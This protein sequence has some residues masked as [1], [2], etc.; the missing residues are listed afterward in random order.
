MF[1]FFSFLVVNTN[2]VDCLERFFSEMT[3]YVWS[4]TLNPTHSLRFAYI[5]ICALSDQ[6]TSLERLRLECMD[7]R[8]QVEE[9]TNTHGRSTDDV[10]GTPSDVGSACEDE[11]ATVRLT[12][13]NSQC[14]VDI[15]Q[16]S[17]TAAAE[18][19]DGRQG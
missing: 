15:G 12:E 1:C 18:S 16:L 7:I 9:S 3:C 4:G 5:G 6:S 13:S 10:H 8:T 17:S 11:D 14:L 19:A 2:A